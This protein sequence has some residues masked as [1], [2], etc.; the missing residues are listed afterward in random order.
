V[1]ERGPELFVPH[2]AGRIETGGETGGAPSR[3]VSITINLS[4]MGQDQRTMARS[5]N[6]V[7]L[8]V[9]RSLDRAERLA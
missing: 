5:A 6:Q 9:R 8:A 1:G 4:G 3:T 7:A 2:A